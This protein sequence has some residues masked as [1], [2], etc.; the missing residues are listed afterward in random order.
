MTAAGYG[1]ETIA[2]LTVAGRIAALFYMVMIGWG[3]GFQ[4]VCA[5]NYGAGK[6]DRVK[7]A[8]KLS[9]AIGTVFLIAATII[10]ALF[11]EP[12][13]AIFS[14]NPEVIELCTRILRF[15]CISLPFMGVYALS[16][17][18]A[19]NIGRYFTAL[20][21][22]VSRQG[23][24]YLPLLYLLPPLFD[25]LG[26]DS[27]TGLFCVQPAADI[28]SFLLGGSIMLWCLNHTLT[29]EQA[30]YFATSLEEI[31]KNPNPRSRHK[32]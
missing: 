17:M 28:A 20:W 30:E 5:M 11:A 19:Q 10:L 27:L 3:Q 9:T 6:Y 21:I 1:E 15:Q 16:S 23:L 13:S 18:F 31:P 2:A 24:F 32:K 4:P 12:L 8:L 25:A 26:F 22:S 29:K 14:K 7:K